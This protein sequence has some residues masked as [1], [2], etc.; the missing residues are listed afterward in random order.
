MAQSIYN[1]EAEYLALADD[2]INN[3]GEVTP[4]QETALAINKESLEVKAVKYGYVKKQLEDDLDIIDKEIKRLEALK[5]PKQ[6]LIAKLED[7]V[8][9]AMRL[10]G[11]NEIKMQNLTINF[12]AS[13]ATEIENEAIIPAKYKKKLTTVTLDKKQL[14]KDL[15]EGKKVKGA[16]LKENKNIQFK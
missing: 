10:Y 12:R 1:I 5:K 11:I 3:G 2:I 7:T 14:L 6:T 13:T 4:E 16:V 9:K 15:R 8:D